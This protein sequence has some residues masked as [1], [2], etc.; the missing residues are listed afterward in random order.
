MAR[1]IADISQLFS[2]ISWFFPIFDTRKR[3]V[4][5]KK[6]HKALCGL[7]KTLTKLFEAYSRNLQFIEDLIPFK[8]L[9]MVI[10]SPTD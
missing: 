9:V 1:W 8:V 5:Y 7:M 2:E 4:A 10:T 3:F 6:P